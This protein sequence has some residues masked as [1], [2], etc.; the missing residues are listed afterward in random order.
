MEHLKNYLLVIGIHIVIL[1]PIG[2]LIGGIYAVGNYLIYNKIC[3]VE[4]N[5]TK[6]TYPQYLVKIESSGDTTTL[7]IY[8]NVLRIRRQTYVSKNIKVECK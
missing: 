3:I 1:L 2:L 4:I 8:D 5:G 6:N 7:N